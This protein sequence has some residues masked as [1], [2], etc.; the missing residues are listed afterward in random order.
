M[1]NAVLALVDDLFWKARLTEAAKSAG[2]PISF[3]ADPAALA[4]VDPEAV[5][6]VVVDLAL[7]REPF[8]AI[9][10]LKRDPARAKIPVVGYFEHMRV[11]LHERGAAAGIDRL[12]A[13]STFTE[14]LAE[15]FGAYR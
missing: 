8:E 5:G 14:R 12:V 1:P 6:L 7:R 10:A 13:R 3:S 4:G 2:R 15:L 11:D 9:S